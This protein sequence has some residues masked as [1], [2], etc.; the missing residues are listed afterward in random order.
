MSLLAGM[1][2]VVETGVGVVET[3][4]VGFPVVAVVAVPLLSNPLLTAAQIAYRSQLAIGFR[5]QVA[6]QSCFYNSNVF[7]N[8]F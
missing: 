8:L 5:K 1:V 2:V 6:C 3:E 7:F 4:E